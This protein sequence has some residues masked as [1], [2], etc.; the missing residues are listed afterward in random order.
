[1]D[2]NLATPRRRL[3]ALGLFGALCGAALQLNHFAWYDPP[4]PHEPAFRMLLVR[5]GLAVVLGPVVLLGM[6]AGLRG[7]VARAAVQTEAR[8]RYLEREHWSWGVAGLWLVGAFGVRVGATL[9]AAVVLVFLLWQSWLLLAPVRAAEAGRRS[10]VGKL[11]VLF[12]VSG[13]AALIYQVVWQRVLFTAFGVN[14][15]SIT[16]V[17]SIFMF[18]LGAGSL[19]GGQLSARYPGELPRLFLYCELAI[20]TFGVLSLWLIGVVSAATVHGTLLTIS[21]AI[22]ALLA[23]P[24]LF[25]G[26]TLPILVAHLFE[27]DAHIG[28]SVGLLYFANTIGSAIACFAT[29]NLIFVVT[30]LQSAVWIAALCNFAVGGM[31]FVLMRRAAGAAEVT[32]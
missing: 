30:G 18:G 11:A 28:R 17:V 2:H 24:T 10:N 1:M 3:A 16:I 13:F 4:G 9:H 31:V 5:L 19:V 6:R 8:E 26:A 12:L 15:E 29:T 21:L 25:M 32:P 27:H 20:G 14:I 7:L 22:Y 23:I